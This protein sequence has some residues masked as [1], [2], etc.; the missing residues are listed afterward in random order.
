MLVEQLL[1]ELTCLQIE[2][3][4]CEWDYDSWMLRP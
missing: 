1:L 4:A 3:Y 2:V